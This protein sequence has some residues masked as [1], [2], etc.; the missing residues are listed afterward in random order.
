MHVLNWLLKQRVLL[1]TLVII[2]VTLSMGCTKK[3]DLVGTWENT[4]VQELI[5]FKSDNS[6]TIQGK[7]LPP[8][9]FAWKELSKNTYI[10]DVDYQG[11]KKGLKGIM[12]N[13]S[14]ILEGEGGKE[15]YRKLSAK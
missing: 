13:D 11:Q 1:A 15:T 10:L 4:T 8:L 5:E 2:V 3:N 9:N 7:N 12:Q 6:G 14:L